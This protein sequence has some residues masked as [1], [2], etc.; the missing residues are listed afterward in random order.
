MDDP[1]LSSGEMTKLF[2]PEGRVRAL[3]E[4]E[5]VLAETQAELGLIPDDAARTI[6]SACRGLEVDSGSILAQGW[7]EGS[8]L[9]PLLDSVRSGL[10]G[11][12]SY[13]HWE[14]TTQDIVD[15]AL[16][17]RA[18]QAIGVLTRDLLDT[19]EHLTGLAATHRHTWMTAR[20]FL[21]AARPIT[22]GA[23]VAIWLHAL[24]RRLHDLRSARGGLEVQLGG[25]VGVGS[26]MASRSREVASLMAERLGLS[27]GEIPWQADREPMVSLAA[28]VAGVARTSEK[29][30]GD[31]MVLAQTEV[32]EVT[33]RP[34]GS[35]SMS[36]KANPVDAMRA[37][38]GARLAV[39]AASGL[40]VAPPPRL[41]RDAGAWQ[42]E[43]PL[44][45]QTFD[46][47]SVSVQAVNRALATIEVDEERMAA[48]LDRSLGS[49]R[50][51]TAEM[52]HVVDSA[53]ASFERT[54]SDLVSGR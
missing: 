3:L 19:A 52:D 9:I 28:A 49:D 18:S 51:E 47:T 23:K 8:V 2:G 10:G 40:L 48:N 22:F 13:L 42:A 50:P 5:A 32:A 35:T 46:G 12:G 17:W 31:L 41:E 34:G 45:H 44:V 29:L 27:P 6:A 36:H 4:I 24:T 20:T 37:L 33:M 1:G 54:R 30:A 7:E 38:A 43:W 15:T 16:S 11:H 39:T 25:P 53:I 21:Q 26:G 14:T